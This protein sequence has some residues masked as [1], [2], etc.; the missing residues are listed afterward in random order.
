MARSFSDEATIRQRQLAESL[1]ELRGELK[2]HQVQAA[3]GI[4]P[5]KLSRIESCHVRA[6]PNDVRALVT[7]YGASEEHIENLVQAA[8]N[9]W[10]STILRDYIGYDWARSIRGHLE[11]EAEASNITS[12]TIDLVPGLLQRR[13]YTQTLIE[14]RPDVD[15]STLEARLDFR[16]RRQ[17]RV[18]EGH[19]ELHAIISEAVLYQLIG[20]NHVLADQLTYLANPEHN[21]TIQVIPFNRGAHGGLGSSF[22]VFNFDI[23]DSII[24]QDTIRKAL[25]QHDNETVYNHKQIINDLLDTALTVDESKTLLQQ[26]A[27]ELNS[28]R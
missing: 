28:T 26:R 9:A 4:T 11:L 22:H 24:Y 3:T 15:Q 25:Y 18:R 13:N 12:W 20:G 1:R 5:S 16:E 19:L 23:F 21:V 8:E 6:R 27:H 7:Y 17:Q 10:E 14:S 2:S